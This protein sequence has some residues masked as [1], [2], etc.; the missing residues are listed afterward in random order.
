MG[1][2]VISAVRT[3]R[4]ADAAAVAG[5][6]GVV[7]ATGDS[8][9]SSFMSSGSSKTLWR[10]LKL[11]T[12]S[13][14]WWTRSRPWWFLIFSLYLRSWDSILS[15]AR[16]MDA[17]M[18][19]L[20]SRPRST[21]APEWMVMSAWCRCRSSDNTT[22]A[23]PARSRYLFTRS[24]FSFAYSLSASDE[25]NWR[26]VMLSCMRCCL[27]LGREEDDQHCS[28][29]QKPAPATKATHPLARTAERTPL[30][31]QC[32]LDFPVPLD[33]LHEQC[34]SA[35]GEA[36][37]RQ[38]DDEGRAES[39]GSRLHVHMA[40]VSLDALTDD[41][42]A[43]A[44]A[45][46]SGRA[47]E[48]FEALEDALAIRPGHARTFVTH[49]Q[50]GSRG[51]ALEPDLHRMSSTVAKGIEQQVDEDLL[52]AQ[53]IEAPLQPGLEDGVQS[54]SGHARFVL[55]ARHH[56]GH[57][58]RQVSLGEDEIQL[59]L[60]DAADIQQVVAQGAEPPQPPLD[61]VEPDL[62][63]LGEQG[64]GGVF[65]AQ[66]PQHLQLKGQARQGRLEFVARERQ[67]V[68][69][70]AH[71]VLQRQLR[72]LEL[73]DVQHGATHH[74]GLPIAIAHHTRPAGETTPSA[75][76][77]SHAVGGGIGLHPRLEDARHLRL[78]LRAILG[79]QRRQEHLMRP[80]GLR[81]GVAVELIMPLGA[82]DLAG[83]EVRFPDR[84]L[85]GV[86]RDL[87]TLAQQPEA[88]LR[89]L[90]QGLRLLAL[91]DV[92]GEH[93]QL[94][95]H[96]RDGHLQPGARRQGREEAGRLARLQGR[97]Q[98]LVQRPAHQGRD[99]HPGLLAHQLLGLHAEQRRPPRV[100]AQHPP[101]LVQRQEGLRHMLEQQRQPFVRR[102]RRAVGLGSRRLVGTGRARNEGRAHRS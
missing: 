40:P 52:D 16:S 26:K 43:Q 42:E 87:E 91:G 12:R 61:G 22:C 23:S 101:P 59:A 18:S 92:A 57:Q 67:E 6:L 10:T 70:H 80:R 47:L 56:L 4:V 48:L 46:R 35:T 76:Q 13:W 17:Y 2:T 79:V 65:L 68:L 73:G 7:A 97:R 86:E 63:P 83:D 62:D 34:G 31:R 30:D 66:A 95:A 82:E 21:H 96:R 98:T 88:L 38:L 39:P 50:P 25:P 85:R 78:H 90:H 69:A 102:E 14:R 74:Q 24:T 3:M 93:P 49:H 60:A 53:P 84:H 27:L 81:L 99:R 55:E 54:H 1:F 94:I 64:R 20:F 11:F 72:L 44:Q 33:F 5:A 8:E 41:E 71:P 15:M 51:R 100:A 89:L 45:A 28:P 75:L 36:L 19:A 29:D 37:Q 77:A 32:R 58:R 9:A